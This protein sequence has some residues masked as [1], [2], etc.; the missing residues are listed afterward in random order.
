MQGEEDLVVQVLGGL[1]A[2][3]F[4]ALCTAVVGGV[5]FIWN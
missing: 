4:C 5:F 1:V 3:G 2:F